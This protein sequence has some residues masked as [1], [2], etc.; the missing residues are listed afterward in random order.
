MNDVVFTDFIY[1]SFKKYGEAKV[2]IV[3]KL[4]KTYL[5]SEYESLK[6]EDEVDSFDHGLNILEVITDGLVDGGWSL[7]FDPTLLDSNELKE[8]IES[9]EFELDMTIQLQQEDI[10]I[11]GFCEKELGEIEIYYFAVDHDGDDVRCCKACRINRSN[12]AAESEGI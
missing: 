5:V 4:G 3:G 9:G 7:C 1:F 8:R 10:E 12:K 2:S 11:C 6:F